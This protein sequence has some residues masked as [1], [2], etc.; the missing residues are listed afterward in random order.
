MVELGEPVRILWGV[1]S[2]KEC[3]L[4]PKTASTKASYAVIIREP[5]TGNFVRK[6]IQKHMIGPK[7]KGRTYVDAAFEQVDG[8]E[9]KA[10]ELA[11]MLARCNIGNSPEA[12]NAIGDRIKKANE[13]QQRKGASATFYNV[14]YQGPTDNAAK[15]QSPPIGKS[16]A[17][18]T[19]Q[20]PSVSSSSACSEE[21]YY[22]QFCRQLK[23]DV[24]RGAYHGLT[25]EQFQRTRSLY[26]LIDRHE[27]KAA[28]GE[29]MKTV[30]AFKNRRS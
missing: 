24:L 3:Y 16:S 26:T 25:Y 1:H 29:T 15:Y 28:V 27:F 18:G 9:K 13:R 14:K 5:T 11:T 19:K 10:N 4:D 8:L 17:R 22:E 2:G 6:K 12:M 30:A 23:K 20:S 21:G 7:G